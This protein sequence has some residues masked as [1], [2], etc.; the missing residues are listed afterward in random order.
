MTTNNEQQVPAYL[1]LKKHEIRRNMSTFRRMMA[2][3][4]VFPQLLES[5]TNFDDERPYEGERL[6][7]YNTVA[8]GNAVPITHTK[9]EVFSFVSDVLRTIEMGFVDVLAKRLEQNGVFALPV[10]SSWLER[11]AR[12]VSRSIEHDNPHNLPIFEPG[13]RP[14]VVYNFHK[15][16]ESVDFRV[17]VYHKLDVQYNAAEFGRDNY[18]KFRG[19]PR[20]W[21][22]VDDYIFLW[23]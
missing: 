16:I 18:K 13:I 14:A 9:Y 21:R 3:G 15:R 17:V 22:M 10:T 8:T 2:R 20:G 7:A 6:D 12:V 23:L 11:K 19:I 4:Y 1:L 5:V